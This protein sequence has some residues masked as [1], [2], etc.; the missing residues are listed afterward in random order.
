MVPRIAEIEFSVLS[1]EAFLR[2]A[3]VGIFD[4][5]SFDRMLTFCKSRD[6]ILRVPIPLIKEWISFGILRLLNRMDVNPV[7]TFVAIARL[8]KVDWSTFSDQS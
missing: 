4:Q 2:A 1:L 7:L 8:C 3:R 6:V 5:L